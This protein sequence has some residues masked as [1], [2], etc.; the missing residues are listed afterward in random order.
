VPFA[1]AEM[2]LC[3]PFPIHACRFSYFSSPLWKPSSMA[4]NTPRELQFI[5]ITPKTA[6]AQN[7]PNGEVQFMAT[8]NFNK[9]EI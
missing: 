6:D 7:F 2:S 5:T 8:G 1:F 4:L 9:A 3:V